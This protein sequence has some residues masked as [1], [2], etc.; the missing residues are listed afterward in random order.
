MV[1]QN[2]V[3][4]SGKIRPGNME[5]IMADKTKEVEQCDSVCGDDRCELSKDHDLN[6]GKGRKHRSGGCSWT[7][8]GAA[9][10]AAEKSK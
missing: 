2:F 5:R 9:R 3:S 8:A 1:G 10:V 4:D 6:R 7:D